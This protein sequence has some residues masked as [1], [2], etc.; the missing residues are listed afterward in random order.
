MKQKQRNTVRKTTPKV[1]YMKQPPP[2]QKKN[3]EE[4][5]KR[6]KERERERQAKEKERETLKIILKSTKNQTKKAPKTERKRN[7][8]K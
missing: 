7:Q 2:P 4:R 3:K 6:R 5:K 1:Q 8:Q